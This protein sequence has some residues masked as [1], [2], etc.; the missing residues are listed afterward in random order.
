MMRYFPYF[1]K[2]ISHDARLISDG[3]EAPRVRTVMR[4]RDLHGAAG[5][6]RLGPSDS[7]PTTVL[8]PTTGYRG[9]AKPKP[10]RLIPP[11]PPSPSASVP[12]LRLRDAAATV[13]SAASAAADAPS[14]RHA[15]SSPRSGKGVFGPGDK[16]IFW[17]D[18][19]GRF[20]EAEVKKA[21]GELLVAEL[22]EESESA[23]DLVRVDES[24][25]FWV[26]AFTP[27]T[28]IQ[29]ENKTSLP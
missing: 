3:A 14:P 24:S 20:V 22:A 26:P 16:V 4:L 2:I 5:S 21:D 10:M 8:S 28:S 13:A 15:S 27:S 11:P 6:P 9:L 17:S 23:E 29:G 25:L 19:D 1:S 18:G 7:T 12:P